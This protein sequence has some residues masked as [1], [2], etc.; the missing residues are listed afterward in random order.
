[1]IIVMFKVKAQWKEWLY[2]SRLDKE[3]LLKVA[4]GKATQH[5]ANKATDEVHVE[6][7]NHGPMPDHKV[8]NNRT[9]YS[10]AVKGKNYVLQSKLRLTFFFRKTSWSLLSQDAIFH[11]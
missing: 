5:K 7:Q 9:A 10:K 6:N 1:M 8:A 11:I 4:L 2:C 3:Q